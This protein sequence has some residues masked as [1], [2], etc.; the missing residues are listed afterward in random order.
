M[1]YVIHNFLCPWKIW[2]KFKT[3]WFINYQLHTYIC[4]QRVLR[5]GIYKKVL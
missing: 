1:E 5:N 3:H 4:Y 2:G